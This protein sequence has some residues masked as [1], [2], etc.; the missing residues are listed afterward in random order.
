MNKYFK[1]LLTQYKFKKAL[2]HI[3]KNHFALEENTEELL[4]HLK[5]LNRLADSLTLPEDT[6]KLQALV[7][8][9]YTPQLVN[10]LFCLNGNQYLKLLAT[11]SFSREPNGRINYYA[12]TFTSLAV[13]KY[14]TQQPITVRKL[15]N[16]FV[17]NETMP[18]RNRSQ[19]MVHQSFRQLRL[20]LKD[21]TPAQQSAFEQL[22]YDSPNLTVHDVILLVKTL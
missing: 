14:L 16:D 2:K 10:T 11:F 1:T 4:E 13:D 17:G 9:Y 6:T 8:N 5:N 7:D 3:L 22:Y 21:L 15:F 18:P 20:A 12:E 19:K